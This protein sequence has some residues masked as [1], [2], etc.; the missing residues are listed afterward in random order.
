MNI[1]NIGYI[2]LILL[3]ATI[4]I[5]IIFFKE[6]IKKYKVVFIS[7]VSIFI[8][9]TVVLVIMPL[10][11]Y[12]DPD[13]FSAIE[14]KYDTSF[15]SLTIKWIDDFPV[16]YDKINQE[17]VNYLVANKVYKLKK[18]HLVYLK[19]HGDYYVMIYS[20][21]K[22]KNY[23]NGYFIQDD[24]ER[25]YDADKILIFSKKA[26]KFINIRLYDIIGK[27]VDLKGINASNN[28]I[29][30]PVLIPH[31]DKIGFVYGVFINPGFLIDDNQISDISSIVSFT[32]YLNNPSCY[33]KKVAISSE[34]GIL[35]TDS[36]GEV[37]Y[38]IYNLQFTDNSASLS[39][40]DYS[41][42]FQTIENIAKGY[43]TDYNGSI[44]YLG[45]ELKLYCI[46]GKKSIYIADVDDKE[47]W[48]S[49]IP[50]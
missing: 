34:Y 41:T 43:F 36:A 2:I 13:W 14:K 24:Y 42:H 1:N 16:L 27:L 38:K 3:T 8:Y 7:V 45:D 50:R 48:Q 47:N 26:G 25:F 39:P 15:D 20:C 37:S 10:F 21:D 11:Q 40:D 6:L 18:Y 23:S 30:M 28:I 32:D 4:I 35:Y 31:E 33:I 19:D 49:H 12:N 22:D 29:T 17:P 5:L 46:C 44:Y 9:L